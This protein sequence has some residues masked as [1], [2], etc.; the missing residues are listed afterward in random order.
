MRANRPAS[1][2]IGGRGRGRLAGRRLR[3]LRARIRS[4]GAACRGRSRASAFG[5]HGGAWPGDADRGR[6]AGAQSRQRIARPFVLARDLR[7][8][9]EERR[10]CAAALARSAPIGRSSTMRSP[11]RRERASP[12]RA[13]R[14]S[15]RPI[16]RSF[17]LT[18]RSSP[19]P[20]RF[21]REASPNSQPRSN[22]TATASSSPPA[23]VAPCSCR[24]SGAH[25]P[26]AR[27]FVRH[28]MAKAGLETT[29]WPQGLEARRFRA[30]SFGAPWRRIDS[31]DIA[32]PT[33]EPPP[34]LH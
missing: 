18:S 7:H 25:V 13:S 10:S 34:I 6:G 16:S 12:T 14:R 32:P 17:A 2:D 4:L 26:D 3:R 31:K 19:I 11:T 15:S 27:A 29:R 9:D 8:P 22:P 30:E 23:S 5:L 20:G 21:R 1:G 28:L 33:S 24:A